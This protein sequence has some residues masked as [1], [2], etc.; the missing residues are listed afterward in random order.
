MKLKHRVRINIAD[1]NGC[2]QEVLQSGRMSIPKKLLTFL[3]GEFC[4]VL[5]L[6]PGETVQGIEIRELRGE[7]N[8]H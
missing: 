1:R 8:E 6:T 5:V 3:F 2:R 4:E 7:S